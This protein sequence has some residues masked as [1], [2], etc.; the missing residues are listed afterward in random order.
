MANENRELRPGM[1]AR[2]TVD[3]GAV[4]NIVVPDAAVMKL[5]GSGQRTVFVLNADN[6]VSVRTVE[7]GRHFGDRYEILS[8]LE[9]GEQVL[10]GGHSN[11]KSGDKV[12]VK[13]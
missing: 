10:T 2:V 9:E 13:R 1:Y 6:T 5:Q 4:E 12:E 3:Y 11:L 8:G 7:T